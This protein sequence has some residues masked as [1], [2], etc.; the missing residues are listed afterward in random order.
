MHGLWNA[1]PMH[2]RRIVLLILCMSF[3][4]LSG[5]A[6]LHLC[7]PFETY[8]EGIG[9][10]VDWQPDTL[11]AHRLG[12]EQARGQCRSA[13]Q[14][15]CVASYVETCQDRSNERFRNMSQ[16]DADRACAAAAPYIREPGMTCDRFEQRATAAGTWKSSELPWV[17]A[18]M[19]CTYIPDYQHHNP[20]VPR[21]DNRMFEACMVTKGFKLVTKTR[22]GTCEPR[23]ILNG[24]L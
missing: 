13:L 1:Y 16:A 14:E 10:Y 4:F 9:T 18:C 19:R 6:A 17:D 7:G 12:V 5:C 24:V 2:L 20:L 8:E 23:G 15:Q 3:S 11:A 21:P 22:R